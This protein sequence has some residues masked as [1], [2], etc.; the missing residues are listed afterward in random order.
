MDRPCLNSCE[1]LKIKFTNNI[2]PVQGDIV[3]F[4]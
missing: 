1:S 2:D 4:S 3:Q